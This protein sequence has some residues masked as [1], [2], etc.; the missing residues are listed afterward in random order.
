MV[1]TPEGIFDLSGNVLEWTD[2]WLNE[3]KD[4]KVLRGGS[5]NL[6][7]DYCRC[8]SPKTSEVFFNECIFYPIISF[9]IARI[10]R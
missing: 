2:S 3:D 1:K 5:W 4:Y 6:N 8:A 7:S 9:L 10:S